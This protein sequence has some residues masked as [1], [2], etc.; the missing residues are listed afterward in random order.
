MQW[1]FQCASV[2]GLGFLYFVSAIP[3]G[4]AL[5]LP[6]WLAAVAAWLGYASGGVVVALAGAPVRDWLTRR[7][8]I[9]PRVGKPSLVM[10]A[11]DRF[12]LPALGL[13]APVTVGP[14]AGTLLG[15]ALGAPKGLL[16][17]AIALGALP[18]A[19]GFAVVVGLGVKLVK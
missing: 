11:W 9:G 4:A 2:F 5:G 13:L 10:R 14:Q 3:A 1:V 18:W 16:V 17:L 12:G 7:F 15:L 19:A 6:L 8:K